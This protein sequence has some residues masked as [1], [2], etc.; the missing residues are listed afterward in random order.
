M[1]VEEGK[2]LNALETNLILVLVKALVVQEVGERMITLVLVDNTVVVA[3]V[4]D[5]APPVAV[6]TAM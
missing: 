2:L 6:V 3:V 5:K 1:E 4:P